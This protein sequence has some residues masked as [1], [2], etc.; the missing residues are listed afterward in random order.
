MGNDQLTDEQVPG[1]AQKVFFCEG[2]TYMKIQ[3]SETQIPQ[4]MS[5]I[6]QG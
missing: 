5:G 2:I 1:K 6:K 3:L 4:G